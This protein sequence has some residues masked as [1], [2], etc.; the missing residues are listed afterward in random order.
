VRFELCSDLVVVVVVV[1]VDILNVVVVG[2][3]AAAAAGGAAAG[4]A[5]LELGNAARL[6]Q[7]D[8]GVVAW[9]EYLY[10]DDRREFPWLH[11]PQIVHQ[12]SIRQQHRLLLLGAG[13]TRKTILRSRPWFG[14]PQEASAYS[15]ILHWNRDDSLLLVRY[16]REKQLA[17]VTIVAVR[18]GSS[19]R[20]PQSLCRSH[21]DYY[22]R[23]S[24]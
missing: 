21:H 23:P 10:A 18:R 5:L 9:A 2:G 17:G 22:S 6:G 3:G 7:E 24:S 14:G 1:E 12:P 16:F 15:R 4:T 11:L 20:L 8:I 19:T 13:S